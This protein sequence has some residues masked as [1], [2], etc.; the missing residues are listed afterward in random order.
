MSKLKRL[1]TV[2]DTIVEIDSP[3]SLDEIN[4]RNKDYP[5]LSDKK[6][7]TKYSKSL[8]HP[9]T[10]RINGVEHSIQYNFCDDQFCKW[11]GQPQVRFTTVK[12]KPYRYKLVGQSNKKSIQCNPD[13][14]Y[15]N[16]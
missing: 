7:A 1:A 11:F 6:F 9:V 10:F 16:R 12:N 5:I 15:P 4:Q 14:I 8:F 2:S 3:F 13:P